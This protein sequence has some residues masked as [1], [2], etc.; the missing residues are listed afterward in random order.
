MEMYFCVRIVLTMLAVCSNVCTAVRSTDE[1][2]MAVV[3]EPGTYQAQCGDIEVP[4]AVTLRMDTPERK[5]V[6]SEEHVLSDDPAG[7][8]AGGTFL[9][10][11]CGP[12]DRYTRL[13][14]AIIPESVKVHSEKAGGILYKEEMDY[15]LDHDWGGISRVSTSSIPK[16]AKVYIDY[17]VTD[18]RLDIVQISQ[19][20]ELAV[21]KGIS[22]PVCPALP[23][24]DN[25]WKAL[26]SIYVTH[27]TT[28][29]EPSNI[30]PMPAKNASWRDYINVSGG[31]YL[32]HTK[33]LLHEGKPVTIVCWG[34]SVTQGCS[35]SVHSKCY[36]ELFRASLKDAYP[37]SEINL[38]NAGIGGT[39]TDSRRD[40]YD[41]EVLS[42]NPDLITVEF[43]ND[44]HMPEKIASNWS[45]FIER[46]RQSNPNVEFILLT[47]HFMTHSWNAN[48]EKAAAAMRQAA[49][50]NQVALGDT[51][52]I[53]ANLRSLGIPYETLLANG[54]NHPNDLGHEFFAATLMELLASD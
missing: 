54:I 53:W 42:Y 33:S 24:A 21:K 11:T 31:N 40:G 43:V 45:E 35:P 41:E 49:V 8:F 39:T 50:D 27:R 5:D 46:A 19:T 20:G 4:T 29:I 22:A 6:H 10:L 16:G 15:M 38:R 51:A 7:S 14:Y 9:D 44:V 28:V 18:E 25:G 37:N 23:D 12:V 36:V 17:A 26:D 52:H 2:S 47:P 32:N 34:D 1:P 13:P 3:V 30:Y 48:F